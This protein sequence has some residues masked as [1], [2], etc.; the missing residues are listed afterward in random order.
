MVCVA[1]VEGP[2]QSI[3]WD[4]LDILRPL[5]RRSAHGLELPYPS[6]DLLDTEI[7]GSGVASSCKKVE[8]YLRISTKILD[9][10]KT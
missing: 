4:R 9:A 10:K 5:I 8:V 3:F 2:H 6:F 7:A 1:P